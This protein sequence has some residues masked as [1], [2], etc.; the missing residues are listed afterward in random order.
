MGKYCHPNFPKFHIFKLLVLSITEQKFTKKLYFHEGIKKTSKFF[1]FCLNDCRPIFL[2]IDLTGSDSAASRTKQSSRIRGS[3]M[4]GTTNVMLDR[5][6]TVCYITTYNIARV[7]ELEPATPLL[8][9][10]SYLS[11]NIVLIQYYLGSVC[12][13]LVPT[14]CLIPIFLIK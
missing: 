14:L 9:V 12:S 1:P 2:L 5:L 6:K 10:R 11:H 4:V 8:M 7:A 3:E 13:V